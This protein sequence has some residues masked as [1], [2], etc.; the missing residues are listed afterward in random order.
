MTA[1]T[2]SPAEVLRNTPHDSDC[3]T[4]DA[5]PRDCDCAKLI[6]EAR[7]VSPG[8]DKGCIIWQLADA[9]EYA[10]KVIHHRA[11]TKR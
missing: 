2:P 11:N 10:L 9:L 4:Y 7:L 3:G 1:H 5:P 8:P 6:A